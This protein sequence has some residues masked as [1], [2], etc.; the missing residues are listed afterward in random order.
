[1]SLLRWKCC[2]LHSVFF[3]R[4]YH[5]LIASFFNFLRLQHQIDLFQWREFVWGSRGWWWLINCLNGNVTKFC[6]PPPGLVWQH[7]RQIQIKFTANFG[8]V[9]LLK[10]TMGELLVYWSTSVWIRE[11]SGLETQ[12]DSTLFQRYCFTKLTLNP[13]Q[14]SWVKIWK[15]VQ[16][17]W[18]IEPLK[19]K[20]A[21]LT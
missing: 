14:S 11:G 9:W 13:W 21:G 17:N 1:M 15:V 16:I 8:E 2:I 7:W 5:E 12:K 18:L 3:L 19:K 4:P 20:W 10:K 6:H